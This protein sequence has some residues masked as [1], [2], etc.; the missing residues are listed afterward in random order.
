M[1]WCMGKDESR[2]RQAEPDIETENSKKKKSKNSRY[3]EKLDRIDEI[4]DELKQKHKNTYTAMQYRVWAET[5]EAGRHDSF[6]TPPRG[7]FFKSQGRKSIST[8]PCTTPERASNKSKP[9]QSC[10]TPVKVATLRSTYI[11][12][13]LK[14]CMGLE[15]GAIE[16]QHFQ[17]QRDTL[18]LRMS[19]LNN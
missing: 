7:S 10:L 13:K 12:S 3:E 17:E 19:E 1:L 11:Y 4:I 18:L 9:E 15:M 5:M 14:N 2:K 8:V 6:D 16:N